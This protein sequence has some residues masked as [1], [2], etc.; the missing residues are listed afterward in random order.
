MA[1]T[2]AGPLQYATDYK[3]FTGAHAGAAFDA[4]LIDNQLG[5]SDVEDP[6]SGA[7]A[8]AGCF[9]KGTRTGGECAPCG[10]P[11]HPSVHS[12]CLVPLKRPVCAP[13][14]PIAH[15]TLR[16]AP[17]DKAADRFYLVSMAC[18]GPGGQVSAA[19]EV[20]Y[21]PIG[22]AGAEKSCA[23]LFHIPNSSYCPL[24][25]M[26]VGTLN[27]YYN[28]QVLETVRAGGT[29]ATLSFLRSCRPSSLLFQRHS[30]PPFPFLA[31]PLRL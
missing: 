8:A 13:G 30:L 15:P 29:E 2:E 9:A 4:M 14:P 16:C 1:D 28:Q 17:A 21:L 31:V 18:S 24:T 26:E 20:K 25:L 11:I 22:K 12:A 3:E 23:K 10:R 5:G 6:K 27:N 7:K 19:A